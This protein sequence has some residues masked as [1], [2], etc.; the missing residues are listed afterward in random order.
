MGAGSNLRLQCSMRV[1]VDDDSYPASHDNQF[2]A[3]VDALTGTQTT[4]PLSFGVR[5]CRHSL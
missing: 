1:G 5:L 4:A 2:A 3:F